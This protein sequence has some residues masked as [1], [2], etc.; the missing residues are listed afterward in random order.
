MSEWVK[1]RGLVVAVDGGWASVQVQRQS[2][3]GSCS[4]RSGCGNGVLAEVLGRRSLVLRIPDVDGLRPGDHVT[5]GIRDRSLVAGAVLMYLLPL[6]GLIGAASLLGLLLP[7]VGEGWLILAGM[8]GFG[9][10]LAG[11]R[12]RLRRQANRFQPVLLGRETAATG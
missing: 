6:A 11:V 4:A 8:A 3:C 5:L 2:T 9:L 12:R 10:G 7:G 1:E